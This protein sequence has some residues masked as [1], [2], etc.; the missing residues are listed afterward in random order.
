MWLGRWVE[1]RLHQPAVLEDPETGEWRA[2]TDD[3]IEAWL[4]ESTEG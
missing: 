3:E 1:G 2:A 4:A